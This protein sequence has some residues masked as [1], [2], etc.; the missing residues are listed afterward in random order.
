MYKY[1][2]IISIASLFCFSA[3]FWSCD[4]QSKMPGKPKVVSKKVITKTKKTKQAV[5]TKRS[6][7]TKPD[8]AK[9]P[10][11][12]ISKIK[13][14]KTS[15]KPLD[16]TPKSKKLTLKPKA[17]ISKIRI[18]IEDK[19]PDKKPTVSKKDS[20]KLI[21][22]KDIIKPKPDAS[23]ARDGSPPRKTIKATGTT[24][25]VVESSTTPSPYNP[26]GKIDPFEPLFKEQTVIAAVKKRKK[27]I[28]QTPLEKISLSQLKLVGIIRASSG[29]KALVE[30]SSG[31]GF[32]IKKGTYIGL[33]S[34]K[35]IKIQKDNVIIEEE[36]ENVLGNLVIRQRELKL[37]KPSGEK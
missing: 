18:A 29:N 3:L 7:S 24:T 5:K 22:K 13:D 21:A 19:K 31:K 25:G 11:A 34:G 27:R 14:V 23:K 17:D 8:L 1:F 28:P 4:D 12:D 9:K 16:L 30:E 6:I 36:F 15:K 35:V 37:H 10:K 33:N 20:E 32:V 2:T 26:Y